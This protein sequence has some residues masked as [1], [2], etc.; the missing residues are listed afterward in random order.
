MAFEIIHG[1]DEAVLEFLF[2]CDADVAQDGAS[3]EKKPSARL[4]QEPCLS[5]NVNSNRCAGRP[6]SQALVYLEIYA[7]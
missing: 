1:G 7:E 2:G 3:L 5:V 4:S 6:T